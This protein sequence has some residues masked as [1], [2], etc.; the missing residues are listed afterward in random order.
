MAYDIGI[1]VGI[2]GDAKLKN[3]L[4]SISQETK[5]Y[6]SALKELES[7]YTNSISKQDRLAQKTELLSKKYD[8]QKKEVDLLR[9]KLDELRNAEIKDAD[10]IN[11]YAEKYNKA[12]TALNETEREL[13]E[14]KSNLV[15][16]G[17]AME[18][19]GEKMQAVGGKISGIGAKMSAAVTL[20]LA[21]M[22]AAA[23]K[24]E[25]DFSAS[26]SKVQALSGA[27]AEELERLEEKAL[28]IASTTKWTGKEVAD[29][30]GYMALAGWKTA[31]MLEGITPVTDLAAASGEDLATVSDIITDNL[32]A[33]GL[34]A[35]DAGHFTDVLAQTTA[36]SNTNVT[37]LGEAF[38][39]AAPLAGSMGYSVEDLALSIGLMA[40]NGIKASMAG[41]T[42]RSLF[43]R[44][45][46]PT[47]ES[48]EAMQNLNIELTDAEGNMRPL[49]EILVDM[50]AGFADMTETEKAANAAMLGGQRAISGLL[51][52]ANS[53]DEDFN[54]LITAIENADGAAGN[55]AQTMMNNTQGSLTLM[56][57]ALEGAAIAAGKALAPVV[58]DLAKM[59]QNA[60]NAFAGLTKSQQRNIVKTLAVIAAIGPVLA[61]GGKVVSLIGGISKA[62]G[63][64]LQ[65]IGKII[66]A[67]NSSA[68][69]ASADA[70]AKGTQAA[71]TEKAAAA[72]TL[73]NSAIKAAPYM[74]FVGA[75]GAAAGAALALSQEFI[76]NQEEARRAS[77]EI[78]DSVATTRDNLENLRK[79]FEGN[80]AAAEG[81]TKQAG[82]LIER[83]EQLEG[84]TDA[85]SMHEMQTVVSRLNELYP[86]LGLSINS[87]TGELSKT[88]E[89]LRNYTKEAERSSKAAA[90]AEAQRQAYEELSRAEID[91]LRAT[92]EREGWEQ[93]IIDAEKKK[94]DLIKSNT[95]G[96]YDAAAAGKSYSEAL[97][98]NT[99]NIIWLENQLK[100]YKTTE[101]EAAL[102][103][104]N[105]NGMVEIATG[106]YEKYT[107]AAGGATAA[108]DAANG[109][110]ETGAVATQRLADSWATLSAA[111]K[112]NMAQI[113][114][115][116]TAVTNSAQQ[117]VQTQINTFDKFQ[118]EFALTG[119]EL[120]NNLQSQV[121]GVTR[122]QEQLTL[123]AEEGID[124]GILKKLA[125][126]GPQGAEY[127][128]AFVELAGQGKLSQ[129]SEY[130]QEMMNI[131][132]FEN[133][134]GQNLAD[135][136]G[137]V[138]AGG[139]D[140]I[141]RMSA[142]LGL[143]MNDAGKYTV[144]GLV[145]G[146][147]SSQEAA[148]AAIAAT[149]E[150]ISDEYDGSM[151]MGSPS[152][153]MHQKGVWTIQ[154][155]VNGMNSQKATVISAARGIGAAAGFVGTEAQNRTNQAYNAGL[156]VAKGLATGIR[157]G[158]SAII[159]AATEAARSAI[160]AAKVTLGVSSPSKEFY[161]LGDYSI[162]GYVNALADGVRAVAAQAAETFSPDVFSAAYFPGYV[163]GA[164]AGSYTNVGGMT[165]NVYAAEG[166]DVNAIARAVSSRVARE[167]TRRA[168]G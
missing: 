14:L 45:A 48:A 43:T 159:T 149:A 162:A 8:A 119:D 122:W 116:I 68:A 161:K 76:R 167:L 108:Q 65:F 33:L 88:T 100:E 26:M 64:L 37:Q 36:N 148:N 89:E 1:V 94:Q 28:S 19:F 147:T 131:S 101:Q 5:N 63:K 20:P 53:S 62:G 98:E 139:Q 141:N 134:A 51:A 77:E 22:G 103:V 71:A 138:M 16:A 90:Y 66:I 44:M 137:T 15:Q 140:E 104:E 155:L 73:L 130:W 46:K 96:T 78:R 146:I 67:T 29:G 47:K 150:G 129:A 163:S 23:I 24:A 34:S 166:Q 17:K 107:N 124:K 4:K 160:N 127:V 152:K 158:K 86:E 106:L 9:A 57:S 85:D 133:E 135:A 40:N 132:G 111:E 126:M 144:Q 11:Y 153:K 55:M 30:Y 6:K 87:V 109:A 49:R 72:Q 81:T 75:L 97:Q 99:Q 31:E 105:A 125:E 82:Y 154:G 21:A 58:T 112:T 93:K 59:V 121:E 7:E 117:A 84:A 69:A 92:K 35:K 12:Q 10:A 113:A 114:E 145:D 3:Q 50:R 118:S 27:T 164:V 56:K 110:V 168:V 136:I 18:A 25:S 74:M 128:N 102:A 143:A 39:Y 61:I 42:L 79:T 60:A 123:L 54:T 91:L 2:D 120:L 83:L 41:T 13:A 95:A 115:D 38:K 142:E 80:A 157:D 151:V 32:T 52:I 165:F 70:I 156:M